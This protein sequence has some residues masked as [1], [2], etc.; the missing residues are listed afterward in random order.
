MRK[1]GVC[2]ILIIGLVVAALYSVPAPAIAEEVGF[3]QA[4]AESLTGDVYANPERWKS[5]S[6]YTL[7]S[8]GWN[9]PWVSPP[10]AKATL[11]ARGG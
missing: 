8:E 9:E 11:P 7:F 1:S 5:L 3:C 10:P 6:I 2:T 4:A